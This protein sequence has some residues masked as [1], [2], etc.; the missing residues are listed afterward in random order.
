MTH[1]L[2]PEAGPSSHL[3]KLGSLPYPPSS[4]PVSTVLAFTEA[5]WT[6][7]ETKFGKRV[8]VQARGT[9]PG[10]RLMPPEAKRARDLGLRTRCRKSPE[11]TALLQ[12]A[13]AQLRGE[14]RQQMMRG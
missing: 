12:P 4:D 10:C 14:W 6:Q 2:Q 13:S 9:S 5:S 7:A 1:V 11:S 3:L 8:S